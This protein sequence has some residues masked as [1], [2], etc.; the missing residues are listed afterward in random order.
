MRNKACLRVYLTVESGTFRDAAISV[1]LEHN[2]AWPLISARCVGV[3]G[4][5]AARLDII[6]AKGAR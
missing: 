4:Y 1:L 6:G 3:N 2:L 5:L